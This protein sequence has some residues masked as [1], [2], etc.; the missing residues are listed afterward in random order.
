[1]L[2]KIRVWVYKLSRSL[3]TTAL[4]N[5]YGI[6]IGKGTRIS[7]RAQL[8]RSANPKGIHI[9]EDTS[10]TGGV[11]ILAHDACRELKTDTYIGNRCFIG[12]RSIIMPGI[13]IGDEVIVGAGSVVTK[14]IPSN[15]IVAGNPAKILKTDI[16]C[17]ALGRIIKN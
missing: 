4:R 12:A 1:M 11:L 3:Y 5:V 17:K 9:G 8:D 6:E 13:K 15:C 10:I 2:S 14:D 7:R 16:H